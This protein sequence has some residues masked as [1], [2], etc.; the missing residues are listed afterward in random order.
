MPDGLAE[1]LAASWGAALAGLPGRFSVSLRSLAAVVAGRDADAPHYAASTVKLAAFA[2]LLRDRA[3]GRPAAAGTVVVHDRFG[4]AAGRE[5]TLRQADDQ[6]DATWALL[7]VEADL[8]WLAERMVVASGNLAADLVV[9]RLGLDSVQR[10]L[11]A[12]GLEDAVRFTRLIGDASAEAAGLTNTVTAAGLAALMARIADGSLLGAD[13]EEALAV[14]ARQQHRG[15]IPAG[16]PAGT[17]SAGKSGWVPGV[18]HDVALV[19]PAA[20]PPYLLAVCTTSGLPGPDA[21]RLIAG[22]SGA[23]WEVWTRWHG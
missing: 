22:L 12:A 9:E 21:E 13:S 6:D 7:G 5:F 14:L 2:A 19:R 16:L 4:G 11:A 18:Q 23:T 8:A 1:Q 15:S 10:C 3:A 20:A 17:W